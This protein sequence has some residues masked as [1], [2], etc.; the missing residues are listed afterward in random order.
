MKKVVVWVDDDY[1]VKVYDFY[2]EDS[3]ELLRSDILCYA[4]DYKSWSIFDTIKNYTEKN[5][6]LQQAI[7][8]FVDF[9]PQDDVFSVLEIQRVL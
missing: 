8:Y 3:L 2:S 7:E 1:Q 5:L 9:N 4:A 6:T